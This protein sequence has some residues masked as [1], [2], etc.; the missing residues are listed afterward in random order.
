MTNYISVIIPTFN[1]N[2]D[3][4]N[5]TL[6]ALRQQT[7]PQHHWELIIID[8]NSFK[9]VDLD[10]SWHTN[11]QLLTEPTPGLTFARL[12]GFNFAKGNLIVMVDDDNV[13]SH[14]YLNNVSVIFSSNSKLGAIGGK[15]LPDFE[16]IPPKWL[17]EFYG[18]LALRDLGDDIKISS[19]EN[20]Y[21][22]ISPIGAGMAI[23]KRALEGYIKKIKSSP[24]VITDRSG[25]KLGSGGDNDIILEILKAGWD[26]GY[27]PDLVLHH[28][29][30]KQRMG[31]AYVASLEYQSNK[32]WVRVLKNHN[33]SPWKNVAFWTLH[34]RKLKSWFTFKAAA[35]KVNYIK[36]RAYCGMLDGL[37]NYEF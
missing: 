2:A 5:K 25:A 23:K 36:W 13:L 29:I 31:I 22:P 35:N 10:L 12:R 27:Y 16:I 32:S 9:P 28:I 18:S 7:L 19:W 20:N 6:T 33:I 37:S 1:P 15:S 34:I 21:P 11:G 26:V 4:F 8:N 14:D 24:T 3:R 30:P 17:K